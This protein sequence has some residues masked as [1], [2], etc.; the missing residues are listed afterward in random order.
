MLR[1]LVHGMARST[2]EHPVAR[3]HATLAARVA[4]LALLVGVSM[5]I[6]CWA[7]QSINPHVRG[8]YHGPPL[9][10]QPGSAMF[11]AVFAA[12][13]P[14][15]TISLDRSLERFEKRE[16]FITIRKPNPE[17]AY[18]Q[19]SVEQRLAT[20][21]PVSSNTTLFARMLDFGANASDVTYEEVTS[22]PGAP[23]HD[24]PGK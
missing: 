8:R 20:T 16:L 7:R 24:S 17:Y 19:V 6:G 3:T 9:A 21:A 5:Q 15:W 14:G 12:P 22:S 1:R 10:L 2:R 11:D 23:P 4:L 18:S 13:S